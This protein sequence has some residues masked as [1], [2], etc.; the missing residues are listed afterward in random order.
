MRRAER[1]AYEKL[2]GGEA[3]EVWERLVGPY[4]MTPEHA[5]G[6]QALPQRADFVFSFDNPRCH[7]GTD[8]ELVMRALQ[9]PASDRF[10]L[11]PHSGD[12][13]QVVERTH[14]RLVGKAFQDWLYD[15]SKLKGM[16]DY[17]SKLMELFYKHPSVA[18][19]STIAWN[20]HNLPTT[21]R[22]IIENDGRLAS[23][24]WH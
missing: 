22:S 18:Q 6:V 8:F 10:P 1:A 17:K 16:P 21:F 9:R 14:A 20:V 13:H 5:E 11:P 19:A 4:G 2:Q 12:I 23:Y 24:P 15:D 3:R 7:G